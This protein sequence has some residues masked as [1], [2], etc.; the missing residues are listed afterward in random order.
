MRRLKA[1]IVIFFVSLSLYSA[2]SEL[3]LGGNFFGG[4]DFLTQ[5]TGKR[6][7][8]MIKGSSTSYVSSMTRFG[9]GVEMTYFPYSPLKLGISAGYQ[10]LMPV[11]YCLTDSLSGVAGD[12]VAYINYSFL[13]RH[14]ISLALSYFWM[15]GQEF[16]MYFDAGGTVSIHTIPDRNDKNSRLDVYASAGGMLEK[17]IGGTVRSDY[18]YGG[19]VRESGREKLTVKPLQWSVGAS[20]GLQF[21]LSGIVGL[22]LEPGVI[23]HFANGSEVETA[24]SAHP[25]N[26]NLNLGLRFSLK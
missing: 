8:T 18:V 4:M 20:A 26:F 19:D 10:V 6:F 17:C 7:P 16:G 21:K 9:L 12:D 24:Y 1:T 22:Y 5:S 14:D 23:Y 2:P 3:Y 13:G 15:I 25:L 11:G